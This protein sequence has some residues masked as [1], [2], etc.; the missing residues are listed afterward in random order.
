MAINPLIRGWQRSLRARNLSVRTIE[1]YTESVTQLADWLDGDDPTRDTIT[2]FITHLIETRSAATASV[3][4]RALQ[5]FFNWLT[6][7]EEIDSNPMAKMRPP[8]VPE[9][10]VQVL[11]DGQITALFATCAGRE[12][13]D[14]RDIAILRL[15]LETG[16]RLSEL[17][18]LTVGSVDLDVDVV[19]VLGKG[20]RTRSV[21]FGDKTASALERY[22]RARRKHPYAAK[23]AWWL[24]DRNH[25][26]MVDGGI[27][28]MVRKRGREAGFDLH[29]HQLRHT[30]SHVWLSQGGSEGDLMRLAGWKSRQMLN[31]YGASAADER[32]RAA[33]RAMK[34]GDR[35]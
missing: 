34:P 24:G 3:R 28:Q 5:Q 31:R 16:L 4:Y 29:P 17:A 23:D 1:T 9:Q 18:N 21:P 35:L 22:E 20:R 33:H 27:Q 10:P 13:R 19:V 25:G 7:E 11:T 30:F 8:M 32:A 12:F 15:F 14:R 26:P 6:D 2:A